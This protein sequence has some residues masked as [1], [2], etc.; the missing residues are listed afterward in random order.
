MAQMDEEALRTVMRVFPQGV[1]VV[2]AVPPGG[3]QRG[4]TV[5]SFMSVSL[6]PPL[7]LICIMK[8][9]L[10]HEAIDKAN[11]FAVN[12]LADDQGTISDHFAK[13][14]LTSEEQFGNIEHEDRAGGPSLIKGCLGYLDCNVVH[15]FEQGDHTLYVGEVQGGKVL[16]EGQ[17]LVFYSRGYWGLGG[18]VYKR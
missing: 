6:K 15:R 7:V 2:T 1:V 8:E 16:K 3:E 17:P 12:I 5:S 9:A 18:E 10:A 11:A 4:I 14:N 13:P